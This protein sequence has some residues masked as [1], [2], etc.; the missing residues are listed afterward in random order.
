MIILVLG[1]FSQYIVQIHLYMTMTDNMWSNGKFKNH[2]K[3]PPSGHGG[4]RRA[5]GFG[6]A[7]A[8]A[9]RSAC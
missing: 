5:P 3:K 4:P 9:G 8:R 1:S 2:N 6:T 7:G